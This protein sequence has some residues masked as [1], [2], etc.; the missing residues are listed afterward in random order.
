MKGRLYERTEYY[1]A[2][3]IYS[4]PNSKKK[5][6]T[7]NHITDVYNHMNIKYKKGLHWILAGDTNDLKLDVI[8][9]LSSEMKQ[10]VTEV[11]QLNPPRILDPLITTLGRYYQKPL[12]LPP[13]D[14]DPDKS[15]SP[16]DHKIIKM[17]PISNIN[18]K[19][20]RTKREV[21]F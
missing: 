1:V 10:L 21:T 14:N 5:T 2:G 12:V 9:Q 6:A 18:N 7:L 4:K 16:S 8:L 15:G 13:L 19:P 3:S 17:K 20:A 11:T